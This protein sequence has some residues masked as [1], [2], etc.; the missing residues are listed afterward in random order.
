MRE[1]VRVTM[2]NNTAGHD[3]AAD[4][5]QWAR[6]GAGELPDKAKGRVDFT[7]TAAPPSAQGTGLVDVEGINDYY[8]AK[9]GAGSDEASSW[10]KKFPERMGFDLRNQVSRVRT[11]RNGEDL[12]DELFKCYRRVQAA[13]A[14]DNLRAI[15][16]QTG[17]EWPTSLETS[18]LQ[19][20]AAPSWTRSHVGQ[21]CKA[22]SWDG[23]GSKVAA[24]NQYKNGKGLELRAWSERQTTTQMSSVPVKE[25]V[26]RSRNPRQT[27]F[28]G[29]RIQKEEL[30]DCLNM[31]TE[32]DAT[33]TLPHGSQLLGKIADDQQQTFKGDGFVSQEDRTWIQ[34]RFQSYWLELASTPEPVP[35]FRH[36]P[37]LS[38]RELKPSAPANAIAPIRLRN[39]GPPGWD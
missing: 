29:N 26:S 35:K 1:R 14:S 25:L 39:S 18:G 22:I 8:L 21:Q 34:E 19:V 36:R 37:H 5:T 17:N 31:I 32:A 20:K 23:W 10:L 33:R 24:V 11:R 38:R 15:D 6:P 30:I 16:N 13:M 4:F 12:R 27:W 28:E 3:I 9:H 7:A 2:Q